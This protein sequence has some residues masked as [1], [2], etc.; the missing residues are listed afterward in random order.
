[1]NGLKKECFIKNYLTQIQKQFLKYPVVQH[2]VSVYKREHSQT[3]TQTTSCTSGISSV[4]VTKTHNSQTTQTNSVYQFTLGNKVNQTPSKLL[5]NYIEVKE[6]DTLFMSTSKKQIK[7]GSVIAS[8]GEGT[9]YRLN[10][11]NVLKVF[12]DEKFTTHKMSKIYLLIEYASVNHSIAYPKEFLKDIHNKLVGYYMPKAEG[13]PLQA[14]FEPASLK[15]HFP[16]WSLS[17]MLKLVLNISNVVE[18]IHAQNLIIGD[19]NASNILVENEHKITV[20]DTDSFQVEDYPSDVGMIEYTRAVHLGYVEINGYNTLIKSKYDDIFSLSVIIFQLLHSGQLPFNHKNGKDTYLE[21]IK[22]GYFPYS[23]NNHELFDTPNGS[24][25]QWKM[26][27]QALKDYFCLV[28][29]DKKVVT[30]KVLQKAIE[31]SIS[32]ICK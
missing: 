5:P 29:R 30:I 15:K 23:N 20:I 12:H 25:N 27:P 11:A 17:Q 18:Q 22:K 28:F 21:N 26:V 10:N 14:F 24:K 8:K 31:N 13:I 16:N 19:F 3:V 1:M 7:V 32:T 2:Y 4:K 6:N 9:V